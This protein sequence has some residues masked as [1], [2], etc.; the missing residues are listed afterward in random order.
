MT[1]AA[2]K[3]H[4]PRRVASDEAHAWARSLPLH[5]PFAKSVLR[6]L[7]LYVNGE[8]CCFVS[9]EQVAE[10]T[11]LSLDTVRRRA[12]W[13]DQVGAI[14]RIAQWIDDNG[15]RNSEGRGRRTTDEIRLLLDADPDEIEFHAKSPGGGSGGSDGDGISPSP[16]LGSTEEHQTPASSADPAPALGQ[17]SQ[18]G[19]GLIS[20]PEPEPEESPPTPPSGGGRV[21]EG[22]EEFKRAWTEPMQRPS[23]AYDVWK[24]LTPQ[25]QLRAP[26]AARGYFEHHKGQGRKAPAL[27]SAQ[28]FLREWSGWDRWEQ[29]APKPPSAP[30]RFVTED[31]AEFRAMQVLDVVRGGSPRLPITIERRGRGALAP[32]EPRD[33]DFMALGTFDPNDTSKWFDLNW[34]EHKRQVAAW[35]QRLRGW[36][37]EAAELYRR[38]VPTGEMMRVMNKEYP[39]FRTMS[40]VPTEWPPSVTGKLYTT[41]PP[42]TFLTDQDAQD[43]DQIKAG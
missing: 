3:H 20:E 43:L 14:T 10:D 2:R 5:N 7:A 21:D 33:A 39:R 41:G 31:S 16:Q 12:V 8:G 30:P 9:L 15:R 42:D 1:E 13:L 26:K 11:D 37:G 28:T 29:Y 27:V 40:R 22:W 18:W 36:Y 17:P 34:S 35:S 23:L 19:E 6:A 4:R 24:T 32:A 38:N 25:L